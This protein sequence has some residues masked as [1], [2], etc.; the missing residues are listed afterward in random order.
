MYFDSYSIN[1]SKNNSTFNIINIF[2]NKFHPLLIIIIGSILCDF[3]VFE[4]EE[5]TDGKFETHAIGSGATGNE[6][7]NNG[8]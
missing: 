6:L 1:L 4:F 5:G 8:C 3:A 7:Y 2:L